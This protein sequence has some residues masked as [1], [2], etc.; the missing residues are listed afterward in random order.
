MPLIS[1]LQD[2]EFGRIHGRIRQASPTLLST[3]ADRA[4]VYW[5]VR[6]DIHAKPDE[7]EG[8]LFWVED[9]RGDQVLIDPERIQILAAG[10]ER[11]TL[12]ETASA[13]LHA[14]TARIREIKDAFRESGSADAKL[15]SERKRLR[16]LATLLCAI[17]AHARGNVHASA[18]L[19]EQKRFIDAQMHLIE[20][21]GLGT[22][23]LTRMVD[24]LEVVLAPGDPVEV[25]GVFRMEP[26]PAGLVAAHGYRERPTCW[27]LRDGE[28]PAKLIGI[29]S[30]APTE[31]KSFSAPAPS[32]L[33]VLPRQYPPPHRDPIVLGT[34]GA[35]IMGLLYYL[36]SVY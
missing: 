28:Q 21:G 17:R 12:L 5:D 14:V 23:T 2:G 7:H 29:G 11:K 18:N 34:A 35:F 13:D 27:T 31:S 4:C 16:K 25:E 19:A 30:I 36:L 3:E 9:T 8:Q 20:S 32:P 15:H 10:E 24:R 26:L 22:A 33:V 1:Q 6:K